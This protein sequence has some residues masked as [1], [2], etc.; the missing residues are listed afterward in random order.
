MLKETAI[1]SEISAKSEIMKVNVDQDTRCVVEAFTKGE[2]H[3]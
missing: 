2:L 1:K 3:E